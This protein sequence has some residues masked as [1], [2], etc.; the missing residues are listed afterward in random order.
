[1]IEET[2]STQTDTAPE[3]GPFSL[4]PTFVQPW[5]DEDDELSPPDAEEGE[6][7]G[8]GEKSEEG[9]GKEEEEGE[10]TIRLGEEEVSR[11]T[12]GQAWE[13]FKGATEDE[14]LKPYL[15]GENP[16]TLI[17]LARS[18]ARITGILAKQEEDA[19]ASME[20]VGEVIARHMA[21]HGDEE[22]ADEAAADLV[23]QVKNPETMDPA[24][25]PF[26]EA[27]KSA[28]AI[29][30]RQYEITL[31]LA[32]QLQAAQ[33]KIA[34]LEQGPELL[35]AVKA[36]FPEAQ[37]SAAELRSWMK[38][39]GTENPVTAY[40]AYEADAEERSTTP[41]GKGQADAKTAPQSQPKTRGTGTYD[42]AGMEPS[43]ILKAIRQGK[44][45]VTRR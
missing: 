4:T 1:M 21:A 11:E 45:A 10:S 27:A 23:Y 41:K 30:R 31:G 42:P 44:T 28:I 7:A 40:R 18:G 36:R 20:L 29:G 38:K 3:E 13:Q 2:D 16:A 15:T 34:E 9:E 33:E 43:E 12:L 25:R 6:K 39:L 17:D 35:G 26:Y 5:A 37:I 14:D 8:E 32:Q 22:D 19:D 24:A